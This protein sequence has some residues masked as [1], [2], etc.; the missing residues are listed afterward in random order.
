MKTAP[1]VQFS[2]GSLPEVGQEPAAVGALFGLKPGKRSAPIIGEQGVL[3][4]ELE[5]MGDPAAP[6]PQPAQD[7]AALRKQMMEQ[8]QGSSQNALYQALQ[9]KADVQDSRVKFY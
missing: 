7:V 8:R 2:S 3:I 4:V 5:K 1:A 9:E 6:A